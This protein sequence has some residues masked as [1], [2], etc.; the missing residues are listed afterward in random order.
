MSH[1]TNAIKERRMPFLQL[2]G[3]QPVY[4]LIVQLRNED[5]KAFEKNL[6]ILGPFHTQCSFIATINFSSSGLSKILVSADV[7]AAKPV[8][9]ALRGKRFHRAVRGLQLVYESLQRRLIQIDV[10]KGMHLL[11]E[12]RQQLATIRNHSVSSQEQLSCALKGIQD[13]PKFASFVERVYEVVESKGNSLANY[14][15]SFMGMVEFLMMSILLLE[16][17]DWSMFKDSLR[18]MILWRQICDNNNYG[19]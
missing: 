12:L 15:F 1:L 19:K 11:E 10:F 16:I 14:W 6:P 18:L 9:S 17:Q 13:S 7:I 5:R 4:A 8:E 2:V 3:D